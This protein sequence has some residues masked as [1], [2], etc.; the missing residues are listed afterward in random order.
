MNNYASDA[1]H[2]YHK[3]GR[4]AYTIIGR[5]GK[6]RNTTAPD[7]RK[8]GLV[9]SVTEVSKIISKPGLETWKLRQVAYSALTLPKK[10]GITDDEQINL[11]LADA[12]E[13]AKKAAK[14]GTTV[15][16][17]IERF[18]RSE[19]V[20]PEVMVYVDAALKG[21]EF[22]LGVPDFL[23]DCETEKTFA[24]DLYGG[25]VDLFSRKLNF[26]ADFKGKDF[27]DRSKKLAFDENKEQLAAYAYGLDMPRARLINVFLSRLVPGL[28]QIEEHN[29]NSYWLSVFSATLDLWYLLKWRKNEKA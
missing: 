22:Y 15:H 13:Q 4:P 27:K 25:K 2:Y 1:G 12:K 28:I 24:T 9:P 11:I 7:A 18:L 19:Y 21:L 26:V 20:E 17:A 8:L 3:D 29:N 23:E 5:N 6:E 14:W 10:E 16:G